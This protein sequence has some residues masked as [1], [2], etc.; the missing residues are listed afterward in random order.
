MLLRLLLSCF[1]HVRLLATPWTAIYQSPPPMGFSRQEYWS[2]LPLPSPTLGMS[3]SQISI[4][5]I[6]SLRQILGNLLAVQ[7]LGLYT[8]TAG[9][10]GSIPGGGTK[11]T[12]AERA[13]WLHP[14][15]KKIL[16]L[17]Q[18]IELVCGPFIVTNG[19][20]VP[21]LYL[22]SEARLHTHPLPHDYN[23]TLPPSP[24]WTGRHQLPSPWVTVLAK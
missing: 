8:S 1:S 2:G 24:Q 13:A 7:R 21:N 11:I 16:I 20:I 22:L 23:A 19:N 17:A 9:G 14:P 15:P 3:I 6:P 5:W 12:Q 4:P 10:T 18:D